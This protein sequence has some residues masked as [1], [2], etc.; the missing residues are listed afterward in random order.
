MTDKVKEFTKIIEEGRQ[1][2]I[3]EMISGYEICIARDTQ[4][5]QENCEDVP[6]NENTQ[7]LLKMLGD[8]L[9]LIF[10]YRSQMGVGHVKH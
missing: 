1:P 9:E 2:T 5:L 3:E 10:W 4:W 7:T 8:S 6:E